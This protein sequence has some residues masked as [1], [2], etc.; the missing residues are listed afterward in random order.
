MGI[1]NTT[2]QTASETPQNFVC[3][4]P[5]ELWE[6]SRWQLRQRSCGQPGVTRNWRS[7]CPTTRTRGCL[8][9]QT[10]PRL[11]VVITY[12]RAKMQL[13]GFK[14]ERRAGAKR[15]AAELRGKIIKTTC[16]VATGGL[17]G[18]VGGGGGWEHGEPGLSCERA[19]QRRSSSCW[20]PG[21]SWEG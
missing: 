8:Q 12:W 18:V 11:S 10:A 1:N 14:I 7:P 2:E 4:K 5:R 20:S 6:S 19:R 16:H 3:S 15:K 9:T 17:W 21:L 13:L